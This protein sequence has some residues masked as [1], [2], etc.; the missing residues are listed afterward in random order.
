MKEWLMGG[1]LIFIYFF[2][3]L[4]AQK[5]STTHKVKDKKTKCAGEF[6]K[7]QNELTSGPSLLFK[8]KLKKIIKA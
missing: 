6:I 4:F 3:L 7:M 8:R 5:R 2:I 1:I